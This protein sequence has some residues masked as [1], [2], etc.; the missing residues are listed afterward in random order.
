MIK[1][2]YWESKNICLNERFYDNFGFEQ[3]HEGE[4]KTEKNESSPIKN[5]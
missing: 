1:L 4:T 3:S 2:K 5:E